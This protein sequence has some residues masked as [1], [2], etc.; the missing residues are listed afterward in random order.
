MK[1]FATG[2]ITAVGLLAVGVLV[3][4]AGGCSSPAVSEPAYPG[5]EKW[6][7]ESP[8][9]TDNVFTEVKK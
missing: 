8:S 7:A 6:W 1:E 4:F 5:Y 3:C 2:L 9:G